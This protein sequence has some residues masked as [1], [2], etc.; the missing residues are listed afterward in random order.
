MRI[1]GQ[2][3]L[4]AATEWLPDKRYRAEEAVAAGASTDSDTANAAYRAVPV[5]GEIP[6][7]RMALAACRNACATARIEPD[8]IDVLG[9][10]G[11]TL[12]EEDPWSP[13][14]RIARTLGAEHSIAFAT[15][16]M[17]N[18]GVAALHYAAST[19][20]TESRTSTAL[21]CTAANFSE[22]PYDRWN[23]APSTVLGDGA[24]A[25]L[26]GTRPGPYAVLSLAIAGD[27]R[28]E[29]R[30]PRFHPFRRQPEG[31][32][33]LS[34]DFVHNLRAIREL[35]GI[36]WQR[37]LAD[38]GLTEEQARDTIDVVC[39]VRLGAQVVRHSILAALP[40]FLRRRHL[41]FGHETGHLGPG[42][43]LANLAALARLDTLAPSRRALLLCL[44]AGLTTSALIIERTDVRQPNRTQDGGPQA[45]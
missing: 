11:I 19:L 33:E 24:T 3:H 30:F 8:G 6:A 32:A 17:S 18:G 13:A 22:L 39:T 1:G 35:T 10:S 41:P 25:V 31:S 29:E 23:T 2:L 21:A 27:P 40:A 43:T 45:K 5:A 38:A 20:L 9:Y 26:I 36:T 12:S 28:A 42:D 37:A 7:W 34:T 16:Q 4:A 44:G 14:H 15:E